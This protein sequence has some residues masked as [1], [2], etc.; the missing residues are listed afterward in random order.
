[1]TDLSAF[2]AEIDR[3]DDQ[4]MDL[5][6]RR[7]SICRE[8]ALY[9][10]RH[11]IPVLLPD[12]I[13]QVKARCAARASVRE[14]DPEFARALYALIIDQTCRTEQAILDREAGRLAGHAE[15]DGSKA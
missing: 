2:R 4:I 12:R 9:K 6:G 13:E 8:V 14:V 3:I 11:A 15:P 7:F 5:L 1:M 10:H